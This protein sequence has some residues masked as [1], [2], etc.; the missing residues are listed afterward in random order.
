MTEVKPVIRFQIR[1]S[2]FRPADTF[3]SGQLF[4]CQQGSGDRWLVNAGEEIAYLLPLEG[5]GYE[6]YC[7]S[8][9]YFRRYLGLSYN[10]AEIHTL[11]SLNPFISMLAASMRG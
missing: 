1:D 3:L 9:S 6:V 10:Y 2:Y 8:E 7:S 11:L 5:G 4:R